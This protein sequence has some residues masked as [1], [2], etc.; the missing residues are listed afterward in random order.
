LSE[1]DRAMLTYVE[2]LTLTPSE[3]AKGDVSALR[4]A[5]FVD[6]AILDINQVTSYYAYVNR[7]ADGLGV[8]LET[9]S[10]DE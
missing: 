3:M 4:K 9:E 6:S 5:G 1:A 8:E 10:G 2:K 7:L